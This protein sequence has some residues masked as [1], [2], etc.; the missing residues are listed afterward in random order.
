MG[1]PNRAPSGV[2]PSGQEASHPFILTSGWRDVRGQRAGSAP[3]GSYRMPGLSSCQKLGGGVRVCPQAAASLL[4]AAA[5][6]VPTGQILEVPSEARRTRRPPHRPPCPILCSA[7][8]GTGLPLGTLD[9]NLLGGTEQ[10]R[11][12]FSYSPCH[13][14][15]CKHSGLWPQVH[16]LGP[17][18]PR[19]PPPAFPTT[20]QMSLFMR[21]FSQRQGRPVYYQNEK[22]DH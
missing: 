16:R 6:P 12:M 1:H 7:S 3:V 4:S 14:G 17:A 9:R 11:P 5:V 8:S 21:L 22:D 2:P 20:S 19:L 15:P 10:G 18:H 13:S